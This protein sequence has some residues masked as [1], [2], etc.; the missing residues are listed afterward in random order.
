MNH[1]L[2]GP[3]LGLITTRQT[4]EVFSVLATTIICGHKSCAGYDINTLFPLYLYPN[5]EIEA[6]GELVAH[7]NGRRPNLA[8]GFVGELAGRL[9]L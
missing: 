5:G 8:A 6:Q 4:K 7:E 9:G 2:S 3:N 1:F